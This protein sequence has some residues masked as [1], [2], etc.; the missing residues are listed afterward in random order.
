MATVDLVIN[1][2]NKAAEKQ[3]VDFGK[4]AV[5]SIG[6]VE[7][8]LSGLKTAFLGIGSAVAGGLALRE[9]TQ[10]LAGFSDAVTEI[11]TIADES[12]GSVESLSKS[13]ISTAA[14]FGK[15]PTDQ[16][17]AFYQII[18]AGITDATEANKALI[19]ANKLAIGGLAGTGESIDIITTA[20]NVYKDANLTAEQAS[21]ALF[22]AVQLGKTNVS[23]LA[24]SLGD[25]LPVSKALGVS[26][27]DTT[28]AIA[29]LTTKGIATNKATTGL[30]A[31]F[32][33]LIR[34]Q[35]NLKNES[36]DVAEAF[37]LQAL[38]AKGLTRFLK[39][40][41]ESVDGNSEA[42]LRILGA[43]EALVPVLSLASDGFKG[44]GDAIEQSAN[45][46]GAADAAY[47]KV[48]QAVGRQLEILGNNFKTL[49]L[50]LSVEFGG[51]LSKLLQTINEALLG[52]IKSTPKIIKLLK[53]L[54]KT[55]ASLTAAFV[56]LKAAMF[57]IDLA[58][59][60]KL[61]VKFNGGIAKT[62]TLVSSLTKTYAKAAVAQALFLGKAALIAAA[63]VGIAAAIDFTIRNWEKLGEIAKRGLDNSALTEAQIRLAK[64][65]DE[66]KELEQSGKDFSVEVP[67]A[68]GRMK[69]VV[70]KNDEA[71]SDLKKSIVAT[72]KQIDELQKTTEKDLDIDG[73]FLGQLI[74][75][76]KGVF[77]AGQDANDELDKLVGKLE[78]VGAFK[79]GAGS[80]GDIFGGKDIEQSLTDK[81]AS[82]FTSAID[83]VSD[84]IA[85]M[86]GA[87]G[88]EGGENAADETSKG[89][90]A[91]IGAGASAISAIFNDGVSAA[92]KAATQIFSL[93]AE[94]IGGALGVPGLGAALGPLF[95]SL[96][97][98]PD[99]AKKQIDAFVEFLPDAVVNIVE[100]LIEALPYLVDRLIDVLIFQG[101]LVRIVDGL[102]RVIPRVGIALALA[103][104]R[105]AVNIVA[106]WRAE[107]ERVTFGKLNERWD[108]F[109]IG[110]RE[111]AARWRE[112]FTNVGN[113]FLSNLGEV[114]TSFR[115][116]LT[117]V[118]DWVVDN[119]NRATTVSG[120]GDL[121]IRG[122]GETFVEDILGVDWASGGMVPPGFPN[123][124]FRANLT[125]GELVVPPSTTKN[126]F[127]AIDNMGG[128]T[129]G[130]ISDALLARIVNLLEQPQSTTATATLDGRTFAELILETNRVNAR[131][132]A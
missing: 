100:G 81:I 43:Q 97:Q 71:I 69:T 106:F 74:D 84:K 73:G 23:E 129:P 107:L 119:I 101:G 85:S 47:Q 79:P 114:L 117:E 66:L 15:A 9:L 10:Q 109:F 2:K 108:E 105:G 64:L 54:I 127:D 80:F 112:G 6:G 130:S 70:I 30:R 55:V 20:L 52:L 25:T 62:T 87:A 67:D 26:F 123:D 68:F 89:V 72:K 13:L 115:R 45:A 113:K 125:S 12:V 99:A 16:A 29:A 116:K 58:D 132:A 124:S 131:T 1:A 41:V 65:K 21:D 59:S 11:T 82:A 14:Q 122:G 120:G 95:A 57:A 90:V 60:I 128:S 27:S 36:A 86:F 28:A 102:I 46:A 83:A 3:I 39:D 96:T 63:F 38:Q 77:G 48:N 7:T 53:A 78:A 17:K 56:A 118:F 61:F 110:W 75:A 34:T 49:F 19:A 103:F 5:R 4:S 88:K 94:G 111:E 35:A 121:G 40:A 76:L 37:S 92:K 31:L 50:R 32:S 22:K 93:I 104:V 91:A 98:G 126:L 51:S 42:L 33:A 18:S 44:L 24:G 8:A